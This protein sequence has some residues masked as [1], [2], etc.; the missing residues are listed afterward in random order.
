MGD[1]IGHFLK[2][3]PLI[4]KSNNGVITLKVRGP[5]ISC[6]HSFGPIGMTFVHLKCKSG[7]EQASEWAKKLSQNGTYKQ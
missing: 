6:I 2:D 7:L 5:I 1:I 4:G 3:L